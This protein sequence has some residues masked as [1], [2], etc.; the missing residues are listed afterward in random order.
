MKLKW[1]KNW[2]V[3][4]INGVCILLYKL[5]YLLYE[6]KNSLGFIWSQ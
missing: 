5:K 3:Q 4:N 6:L 2:A 1:K